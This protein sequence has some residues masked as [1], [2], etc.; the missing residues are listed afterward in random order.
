M[1]TETRDEAKDAFRYLYER[2]FKWVRTKDDDLRNV[3]FCALKNS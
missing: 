1:T 3:C 2:V